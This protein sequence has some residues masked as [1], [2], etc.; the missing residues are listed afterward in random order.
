MA[1]T[2]VYTHFAG[3]LV[4]ENR[5]GV[6]RDYMPDP[7][8][9]VAALLD[10]NQNKTDTWDYWPFGEVASRTGT[11]DTPFQHGGIYGYYTDTSGKREYAQKRI[12]N[13]NL[14]RWQTVDQ[15]WPVEP[16][17]EYVRSSPVSNVDPSGNGLLLQLLIMPAPC[18]RIWFCWRK[19]DYKGVDTGLD[20]WFLGV[21]GC[22][23]IGYGPGPNGLIGDYGSNANNLTIDQVHCRPVCVTPQQR[24]CLCH[25][26]ELLENDQRMPKGPS[27]GKWEDAW[28]RPWAGSCYSMSAHNCQDFVTE[29]L[30]HCGLSAPK[31]Q[32]PFP[33]VMTGPGYGH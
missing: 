8:G 29:M 7:N 11:T 25:L 12:Y 23:F 20:H 24:D 10:E 32:M 15:W 30:N 16:P 1:M 28:C 14:G 17:Y 31:R 5:N 21:P 9:N 3:M 33:R 19:V 26:K 4:H 13:P 18:I 27:Q 6:E 22:G 2:V